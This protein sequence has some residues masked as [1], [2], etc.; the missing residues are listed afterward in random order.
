MRS[1]VRQLLLSLT[2][3]LV[4]GV[5]GTLLVWAQDPTSA[6]ATSTSTSDVDYL[7]YTGAIKYRLAGFTGKGVKIGVID[8]GFADLSENLRVS[9]VGGES[10]TDGAETR[11]G[12]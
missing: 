1:H 5:M 10:P 11:H 2:C 3:L 7:I 8:T 9:A 6:V 4:I 12:T